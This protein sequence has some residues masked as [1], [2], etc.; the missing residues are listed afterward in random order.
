ML[1]TIEAV[2]RMIERV[3]GLAVAA[4]VAVALIIVSGQF[5]DRH[6]IDIPWDAPDQFARITIVWLCFLGTALALSEGAAIRID[7]FD[8]VLPPRMLAWRDAVFDLLLLGMLAVLV[9][10]GWTVVQ[11]GASQL[12]LGTPFTAD[13][14]YSG[15]FF[16]ALLGAV[17]IGARILRR[18]LGVAQRNTG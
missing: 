10:T 18:V 14:P 7:L 9:V 11:V 4:L 13:V 3:A 1:K 6:F 2:L 12:I 15:L 5:I 8:H 16:G 17:F